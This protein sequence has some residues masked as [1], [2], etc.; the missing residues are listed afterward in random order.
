M[1]KS[2]TA[3]ASYEARMPAGQLLC[4]IRSVNHRFLE[5][6]VRLP[7]ELRAI[8]P[9]LRELA[10]SRIARGKVDVNLRLRGAEGARR[11]LRLN[12]ELAKHL[13]K[14]A[15]E[16]SLHLPNL[17]HSSQLEAL[18]WPGMLI[19]AE[20]DESLLQETAMKGFEAALDEFVA[21]RER[22]GGRLG[23]TLLDRLA[24]IGELV[25]EVEGYLPEIRTALRAKLEARLAELRSTIDA[26][27]FEQELV[28]YLQ[29]L[30]VDEE[31]DRLKSHVEEAERIFG[32][33]ELA[34]KRLDFLLQEFN[35]EA[36]TLASK[37]VDTRTTRAAVE[38]KVLIE[39][40]REQIQNLE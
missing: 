3:Y 23:K 8:E 4:E 34:G 36:N 14:L 39:Q 6:S 37:S 27:R 12:V 1:V 18:V 31:I 7:E 11:D 17:A 26:N 5:L 28:M 35:R 20:S 10:S 30:D 9:K 19:E 40:M 22:E 29:R 16:L 38:L 25:G 2:M 32:R 13:A 24:K 33:G 21:A 15:H